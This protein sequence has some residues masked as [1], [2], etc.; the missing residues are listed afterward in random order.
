M[1][2]FAADALTHMATEVLEALGSSR[3]DASVVAEHLV[4]SNLAGHDSH[5]FLRLPQYA[6]AVRSGAVNP[7]GTPE[8]LEDRASTALIDGHFCWGPVVARKAAA[9]A[10]EKVR[11]NS[12]AAV[13]IRN[14]YHVGR[15]GAYL[16]DAA[17]EGFMAQGF[18]NGHGM[19]RA[20][21][22]GG[23][24]SL[25]ATNPLAIAVPTRREPIVIDF[26][27][28]TV[29]EGKVR[30]AKAKGES[31]PEGWVVDEKGEPSTDPQ[32]L[33]SGG[34]LVPLG[35]REGHKG[36]CLSLGMDL[37]AGILTGAGA[38]FMREEYGNGLLF[39]LLDPRAFGNQEEF[40][41]RVDRYIEYVRSGRLKPGV[42]E[43]LLPGEPE[44]RSTQLRRRD[45]IDVD[46]ETW[47]SVTALA[48]ELRVPLPE[49]S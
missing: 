43:V 27:T 20:A 34:T 6:A 36:Y 49:A 14:S 18:C 48:G 1:P 47:R 46:P 17:K 22:W 44:H 37:F 31:I 7:A 12:L 19:R 5:G 2:R 28:T 33:Y 38:G 42:E 21:P 16:L 35:G 32:T 9:L 29:A 26:A 10:L 25:L 41:D 39:Q 8:V 40:L 4:E 24:D 13:A 15:V 23:T 3:E 30:L 11:S 45:G